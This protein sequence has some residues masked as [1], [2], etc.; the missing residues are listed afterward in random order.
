MDRGLAAHRLSG[1]KWL[2]CYAEPPLK[3]FTARWTFT[4]PA[5]GT[6]HLW[7]R[8]F[9]KNWASP[10]WWRV[11]QNEWKHTPR[12]L[13]GLELDR[14]AKVLSV[15]WCR[16]GPVDLDAG[17]Q[18]LEIKVNEVR[19]AGQPDRTGNDLMLGIDA[20]LLTTAGSAPNA[21]PQPP[22]PRRP[23]DSIREEYRAMKA[24]DPNRPVFLNL[25]ASFFGP[26]N[27]FERSDDLYRAFIA[28]TDI[29][30]YDHY[31][32]Y[33]WGKPEKIVEIAGATAKLVELAEGKKPVWAIL[34]CTNGGQ[35]VSD[36]MRAP[37][38]AEIKAEVMMA[39]IH[40]A[41]GVGYFPHVWK[42]KYTWCRIPEE[43]QQAMKE[44]N[45]LLT[46]L[47]PVILG[48]PSDLKVDLQVSAVDPIS[49]TEGTP[50]P[51]KWVPAQDIQF[52]LRR[53]DAADYL[54]L[55]SLV[56]EM[57]MLKVKLPQAYPTIHSEADQ[58]ELAR[59]KDEFSV[60]LPALGIGVYRLSR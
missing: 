22:A 33:G 39:V 40:G 9:T 54:F 13:K 23:P 44:I 56:R 46:D 41:K 38:P 17:E 16:Y 50:K 11:N 37:T 32:I 6:Y 15:G 3:D 45:R 4:S 55:V 42:P 52:T 36:T 10:S 60:L 34:E 2:S 30:S 51:V 1:G 48:S 49:L 14:L 7:V 24:F 47:A 53:T 25:T 26:Y 58:A 57:L 5:K 8:E 35:Y 27:K 20:V 59:A 29:V 43:N 21:D 28:S 18:A 12:D 19:T 31:P